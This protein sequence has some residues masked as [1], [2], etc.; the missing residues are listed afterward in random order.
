MLAHVCAC[1]RIRILL[2]FRHRISGD[3][4][5]QRGDLVAIKTD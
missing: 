2:T 3:M 1:R 4:N 5:Y